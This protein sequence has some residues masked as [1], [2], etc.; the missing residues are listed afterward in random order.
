ME[1]GWR[2]DFPDKIS[3]TCP[4]DMPNKAPS[5]FWVK[6][7][8]GQ[9]SR[10]ASTV[11]SPKW[12][13][14][15]FSPCCLFNLISRAWRLFTAYEAHSRLS[16]ALLFLFPSL[17]FTVLA[18]FGRGPRKASATKVCTQTR[19]RIVRLTEGYPCL[20][21]AFRKRAGRTKERPSLY[22]IRC[23]SFRTLPCDEISQVGSPITSFHSSLFMSR[24][25]I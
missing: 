20:G 21:L 11:S 24:G 15:Q 8:V 3:Y 12:E 9:R 1:V 4:S 10:I 2:R 7:R 18:S 17:W 19:P 6:R 16:A 22:V 23:A 5:S 14:L 13:R 25:Y